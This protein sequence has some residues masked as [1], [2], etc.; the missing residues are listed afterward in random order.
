MGCVTH[1]KLQ[2]AR[3]TTLTHYGCKTC[4]CKLMPSVSISESWGQK[5]LQRVI[6]ILPYVPAY[7][8][9]CTFLLLLGSNMSVVISSEFGVY[10][11][12]TSPEREQRP[13]NSI[14]LLTNKPSLS[15]KKQA[16]VCNKLGQNHANKKFGTDG[17]TKRSLER[18]C[19]R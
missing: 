15:L 16:R 10:R 3:S 6:I 4:N 9:I 13:W 19:P 2:T 18:G 1:A 17:R 8:I 7:L 12:C 11:G 14:L 5:Y